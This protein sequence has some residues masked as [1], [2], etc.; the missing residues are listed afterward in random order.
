M[1]CAGKL[2]GVL[3]VSSTG[4]S[5]LILPTVWNQREWPRATAEWPRAT[6]EWHGQR[7]IV[8]FSWSHSIHTSHQASIKLQGSS[9]FESCHHVMWF[10]S[11]SGH[12]FYGFSVFGRSAS[13]LRERSIF[14]D[15]KAFFK[16]FFNLRSFVLCFALDYSCSQN[17]SCNHCAPSPTGSRQRQRYTPH[18]HTHTALHKRIMTRLT[19]NY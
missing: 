17:H 8:R 15:S 11:L 12:V 14:L 10:Q 18:T 2:Y 6:A 4:L 1:A 5:D 16:N 13:I 3:T 19:I 7:S 9:A